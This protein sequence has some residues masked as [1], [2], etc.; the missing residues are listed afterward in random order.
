MI[1]SLRKLHYSQ[2]L[3]IGPMALPF[4]QTGEKRSRL[5]MGAAGFRFTGV[6]KGI[7]DV[8][9]SVSLRELLRK[10]TDCAT[11]QTHLKRL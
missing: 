4:N 3:P 1:S 8:A 7:L 11:W 2:Q 5:L 10:L 6:F 9:Q